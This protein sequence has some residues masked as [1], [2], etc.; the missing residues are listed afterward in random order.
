LSVVSGEGRE[1]GVSRAFV[2]VYCPNSF[3][4]R[5]AS[6]AIRSPLR[7]LAQGT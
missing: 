4:T 5:D 1:F 7:L 6:L 2:F 3:P